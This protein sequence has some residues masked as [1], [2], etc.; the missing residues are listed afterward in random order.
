[1]RSKGLMSG[2]CPSVVWLIVPLSIASPFHPSTS[3]IYACMYVC[4]YIRMCW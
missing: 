3:S 1:M 4:M 2:A